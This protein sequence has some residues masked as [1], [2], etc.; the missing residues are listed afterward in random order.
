MF[1]KREGRS[2][3]NV[4]TSGIITALDP[5]MYETGPSGALEVRWKIQILTPAGWVRYAH[6]KS[7]EIPDI[8]KAVGG[9][10]LGEIV[11]CQVWGITGPA[12]GPAIVSS[13]HGVG[14]HWST[15]DN[16]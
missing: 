7:E 4:R 8:A 13:F 14:G 2:P 3:D 15:R 12:G 5:G 11:G 6:I 9:V 16:P 10:K 1:T